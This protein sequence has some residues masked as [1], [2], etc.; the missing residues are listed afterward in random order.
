MTTDSLKL[1]ETLLKAQTYESKHPP[2]THPVVTL[3]RDHGC[4]G[5][6]VADLLAKRLNVPVYDKELMNAVVA[7]SSANPHLMAQ[8]DEKTRSVWDN[9]I[10]SM[11]SG[12]NLQDDHYRRQLIKVVLG[13]FN[14]GNGGILIGRG[15]H[16][17]LARQNVF[18]VRIVASPETG[19]ERLALKNSISLE[20]AR[21]LVKE[22]HQHRGKF[23]WDIFK[24]RLNDPTTFDLTINTDQLDKYEDMVEIIVFAMQHHHYHFSHKT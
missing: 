24:Q 7:H 6:E 10:V 5:R 12:E 3:S 13:I 15:A 19:A 8:L 16:L 4:G 2:V 14:T 9:W 20:Q 11:L 22:V 17:I 1:I 21:K 18:R 23:V